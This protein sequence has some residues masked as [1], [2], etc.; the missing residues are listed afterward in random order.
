MRQS[1]ATEPAT[2]GADL[3]RLQAARVVSG[4]KELQATLTVDLSEDL[5]ED[6]SLL[7][8]HLCTERAIS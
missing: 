7:E 3:P 1:Q 5:S 6:S 2:T 8:S 4:P